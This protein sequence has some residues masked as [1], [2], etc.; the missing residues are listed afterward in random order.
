MTGF[1]M[2]FLIYFL[3]PSGA[4]AQCLSRTDICVKHLKTQRQIPFATRVLYTL[5]GNDSLVPIP[6][7]EERMASCMVRGTVYSLLNG[8]PNKGTLS[9]YSM[10]QGAEWFPIDTLS[11]SPNQDY[12]VL[13]TGKPGQ[14]FLIEFRL[15][16]SSICWYEWIELDQKEEC[17]IIYQDFEEHII[18]CKGI[19]EPISPRREE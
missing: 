16:P 15:S 2:L 18:G 5:D 3:I 4:L 7:K 8:I 10:D 11:I 19:I 13:I 9:V 14:K 17:K 6:V 1:R 12:E